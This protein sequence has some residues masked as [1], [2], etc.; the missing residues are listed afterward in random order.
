MPAGTKGKKNDT[1]VDESKYEDKK[2]GGKYLKSSNKIIQSYQPLNDELDEVN[3][4]TSRTLES[5][6]NIEKH[7]AVSKS[8]MLD[9]KHAQSII[10]QSVTQNLDR[11]SELMLGSGNSQAVPIRSKR[12]L[13]YQVKDKFSNDLL[14]PSILT[15]KDNVKIEDNMNG[16][17]RMQNF[18][19]DIAMSLENKQ[20]SGEQS[21]NMYINVMM[22]ESNALPFSNVTSENNILHDMEKFEYNSDSMPTNSLYVTDVKLI[23]DYESKDLKPVSHENTAANQSRLESLGNYLNDIINVETDD[24][25]ENNK[26]GDA[27]SE[28]SNDVNLQTNE[29]NRR[30]RTSDGFVKYKLESNRNNGDIEQNIVETKRIPYELHK[31]VLKS[32]Y[33]PS[34]SKIR[35]YLYPPNNKHLAASSEEFP[36]IEYLKPVNK[37]GNRSSPSETSDTSKEIFSIILEEFPNINSK[38]TEISETSSSNNTTITAE[39]IPKTATDLKDISKVPVSH[40]TSIDTEYVIDPNVKKWKKESSQISQTHPEDELNYPFRSMK[41]VAALEQKP[42]DLKTVTNTKENEG[43]SV[44]MDQNIEHVETSNGQNSREEKKQITTT[45]PIHKFIKNV[46]DRVVRFFHKLSPWNYVRY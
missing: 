10:L 27:P 22:P 13:T 46:A 18:F 26:I 32:N 23:S 34:Y 20:Q 12:A 29:I 8:N 28:T 24:D 43:H 17:Y 42:V 15:N 14:K 35:K 45:G 31:H 25:T 39:E 1:Q 16:K 7:S 30:Y 2:S 40:N 33:E 41:N 38:S 6:K 19:T 36:S 44:I 4:S 3:P 21:S 11:N 9:E 5:M 37:L